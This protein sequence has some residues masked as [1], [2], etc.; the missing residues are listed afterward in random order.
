MIHREITL[1]TLFGVSCGTHH[2]GSSGPLRFLAQV[3]FS[4][5][6][7]AQ[8]PSSIQLY[9]I[10]LEV[11]DK[12]GCETKIELAAIPLPHWKQCSIPGDLIWY[13]LRLYSESP[14]N[15]DGLIFATFCFD[16]D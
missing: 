16:P 13:Q 14:M 8:N 9:C 2:F 10:L 6:L 12:I 11:E 1:F 4:S 5:S 3:R 7:H 15:F